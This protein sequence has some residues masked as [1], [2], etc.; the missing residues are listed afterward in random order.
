M[1]SLNFLLTLTLSALALA[2]LSVPIS[3][4]DVDCQTEYGPYKVYTGSC[5]DTN[6]GAQA[7]NCRKRSQYCV[8]YPCEWRFPVISRLVTR[9]RS[10]WG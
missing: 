7:L 3:G 5:T 1:L 9:F 2:D 10:V 4:R 8:P 6:C